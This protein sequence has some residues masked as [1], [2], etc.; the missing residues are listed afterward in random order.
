[1]HA[2]TYIIKNLITPQNFFYIFLIY[3]MHAI[4][5]VQTTFNAQK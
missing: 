2:F 5:N 3:T 4:F 1:M